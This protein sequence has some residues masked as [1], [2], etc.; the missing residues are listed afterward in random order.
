LEKIDAKQKARHDPQKHGPAK[1]ELD[2][3]FATKIMLEQ[4]ARALARD[5]VKCVRALD[6]H[7]GHPIIRNRPRGRIG[8]GLEAVQL[9]VADRT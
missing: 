8:R 3:G 4:K 7:A 6:M 5:D 1:A 9:P 2:T